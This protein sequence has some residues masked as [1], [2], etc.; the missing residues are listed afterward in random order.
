MESSNLSNSSY[1]IPSILKLSSISIPIIAILYILLFKISILLTIIPGGASP[2]FLPAGFALGSVL[3]L[4]RKALIGVGIGA[5][6]SNIALKT[7][8]ANVDRTHI[9]SGL[10]ITI[11]ILIAT[12]ASAIIVNQFC[13][14]EYPLGKG[15]YVLYLLIL[16]S[17][18][19]STITSLIGVNCIGLYNSIPEEQFWHTFRTWWFGDTIGIILITPLLLSTF[20]KEPFDN[21]DLNF[22]E[23]SLYLLTTLLLCL[24][25]FFQYNDLKYLILPLLFWSAY[26][27]G[28]RITMLL[29]III[30]MLA[31]F[32]TV[33]GIGSF[34]KEN[35]NDSILYLD[36]FLGVISICS[37][38][39]T[40]II[41]ERKKTEDLIKT[42]QNNL[43]KN[44][45]LLESTIESP[46]NVSIY[47]I[48]RNYEYLSFNSQHSLN[49]KTM[50]GIEITLGMKLQ[51]C[52][53]NKK[54]LDG[55]V[56]IL[57]KAFLG[58]SIT[59]VRNFEF[60]NSYWEFRISPIVNQNDKIIGATVISTDITEIKKAASALKESEEK[61]RNIFE[62]I[63][64]V[65]FQT[66]PDG[67]FINI[68][69]SVETI[70]G[71]TPE[72]LI[73][74]PTNVLQTDDEE[75]DA[76]IRLINDKFILKNFEKLLK[77]KSGE[78]ICISLNAKMIFDKNGKPHHIDA[79]AQDITQRKEDEKEIAN[80]NNK[81]Q[82]QN[83]ELEQ[84][85]Y[86]T[87]HDLQEPLI[88]LKYFSELIKADF[89]KDTNEDIKQYLD[90]ILESSNRMQTLVKGLLDYSRIGNR[91]EIEKINCNE[92]IKEVLFSLKDTI[93]ETNCQITVENLPQLKGLAAELIQLFQ[94]LINNSIKFRKKEIQLTIYISA[95][96]VN[97]DWQFTIKDN[98]IGIKEHDL[99]KA[100][101][102]FKRLNNRDEYSGIG[103]GLSICKKIV[104]L[105]GGN[106]WIESIFGEGTMIHFT[107][108]NQKN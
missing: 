45:I 44:Q 76:V 46:K 79:I 58:E 108:S 3:I 84:F 90:F 99:E 27:F 67:I 1:V 55:A 22:F 38:F 40:G 77:T 14:K 88:T 51:D 64:D 57:N 9:L 62:N 89:P 36:L 49:I 41:S 86:I 7:G 18:T 6:Y 72:E 35:I 73:G 11:G 102:I 32:T 59:T 42:S 83:K 66:D 12:A 92:L 91:I 52:I 2:I 19:Y 103:I 101:V 68:S 29:I 37:L 106:I 24:G 87:S 93:E 105:H 47:S 56:T 69:P 98:G 21:V 70:T 26:R 25:V 81:L 65:I 63:Q 95:K 16:G 31:V 97:N 48:G 60:N 80:Q 96:Q 17:V 8:L 5:I 82:I 33:K 10:I 50:Y 4:G 34:Y 61:Y 39:L 30:S 28:I 54:E 94:N 100:F 53:T 23:L 43:L 13:K 78:I 85:A 74:S 20:S 15:K 75:P 104:A 71:F 107:I